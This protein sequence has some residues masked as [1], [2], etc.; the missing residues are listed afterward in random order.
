MSFR[1]R[2][3]ASEIRTDD[4]GDH[5]WRRFEIQRQGGG[6]H[7]VAANVDDDGFASYECDCQGFKYRQRCSHCEYAQELGLAELDLEG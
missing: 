7:V 2:E 5:H 1:I 6:L 4:D 3:L